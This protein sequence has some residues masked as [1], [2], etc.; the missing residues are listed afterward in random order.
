MNLD[1]KFLIPTIV[2]AVA[3]LFSILAYRRNRRFANENHLFE[4]K[5]EAYSLILG[6]LN[7]LL[8]KYENHISNFKYII[9]SSKTFNSDAADSLNTAANDL[10]RIS[11]QF[12]SLCTSS[13]LLLPKTM[14]EYIE[15]L[16]NKIYLTIAP[17][18][19]SKDIPDVDKYA[20]AVYDELLEL[21]NMINQEMR[22]DLNVDELNTLLYRRLKK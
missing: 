8:R 20:D 17:D 4:K 15:K 12:R 9:K 11:D 6:E 5:I 22:K 21:S 14:L 13:S 19:S 7:Q 3:A 1:Y 18:F 2:S 16:M 10:D